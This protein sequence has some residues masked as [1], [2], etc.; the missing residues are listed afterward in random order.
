[1]RKLP[2]RPRRHDAVGDGKAL[3]PLDEGVL[4]RRLVIGSQGG[5]RCVASRSQPN[6]TDGAAQPGSRHW[7]EHGKRT[8]APVP[9]RRRGA[10][11]GFRFYGIICL[12][13]LLA[14]RMS[15]PDTIDGSFMKLLLRPCVPQRRLYELEAPPGSRSVRPATARAQSGKPG[16]RLPSSRLATDAGAARRKPVPPRC[17]AARRRPL[18]TS[19]PRRSRSSRHR[20][21]SPELSA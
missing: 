7:L 5:F 8:R 16:I 14:A 4:T 12:P 6:R 15:L 21:R 1:M 10:P 2:R 17:A 18:G 19:M 3:E 13:T 11:P 20:S 9:G